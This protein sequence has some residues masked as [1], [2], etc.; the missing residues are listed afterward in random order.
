MITTENFKRTNNDVNGNPRYIIHFLNLLTSKEQEGLT[1]SQRYII[2]TN[3]AKQFGGKKYRGK[4][5]GGGLV[6]QSYNL[7]SL[8]DKLNTLLV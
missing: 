8:C 5:Y 4:D 1:I 7:Q 6:F 2:A 3:K